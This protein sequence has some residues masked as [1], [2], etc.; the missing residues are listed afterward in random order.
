MLKRTPSGLACRARKRRVEG[1]DMAPEGN[2]PNKAEQGGTSS[3]TG[4]QV[5]RRARK[6]QDTSSQKGFEVVPRA[7]HGLNN[8]TKGLVDGDDGQRTSTSASA[9]A[10]SSVCACVHAC[11]RG[12]RACVCV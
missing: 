10:S 11:V 8:G 5:P 4:S 2:G 6:S 12:V 9:T 7:E 1:P 3:Q